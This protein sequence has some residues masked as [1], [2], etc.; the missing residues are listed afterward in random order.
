VQVKSRRWA[1]GAALAVAAATCGLGWGI[2]FLALDTASPRAHAI[3]LS[4]TIVASA[5]VGAV[6]SVRLMPRATRGKTS[7]TAF[8]TAALI[9]AV[10]FGLLLALALFSLS[11]LDG[12]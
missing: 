3:V 2:N 8:G 1:V 11:H 4:S 10:E 5:L 9:A 12:S 6:T 7:I